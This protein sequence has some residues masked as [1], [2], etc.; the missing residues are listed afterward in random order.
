MRGCER[1]EDK[2][3]LGGKKRERGRKK[4]GWK[5]KPESEREAEKETSSVWRG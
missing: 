5:N 3:K 1:E 4:E 2:R